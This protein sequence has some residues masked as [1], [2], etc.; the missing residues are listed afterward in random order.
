M[1][2]IFLLALAPIFLLLGAAT[3]QQQQCNQLHNEKVW[4][5]EVPKVEPRP[6]CRVINDVLL[7]SAPISSQNT[8]VNCGYNRSG[9]YVCWD[10]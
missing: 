6:T 7:C 5:C 3:A 2:R 1:F 4:Q 10:N 8:P 9:K